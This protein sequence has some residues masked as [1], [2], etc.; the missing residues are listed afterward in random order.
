MTRVECQLPSGCQHN[1]AEHFA[2]IHATVRVRGVVER[3]DVM[4]DCVDLSSDCRG[5]LLRPDT[6][7]FGGKTPPTAL[8]H[9]PREMTTWRAG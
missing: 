3:H 1:A 6:C 7:Q 9:T 8:D 4:H 5:E 2:R